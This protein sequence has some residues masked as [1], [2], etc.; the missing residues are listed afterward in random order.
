MATSWALC[1]PTRL[2]V[3]VGFALFALCWFSYCN[4]FCLSRYSL[5]FLRFVYAAANINEGHLVVHD[6]VHL[7][8]IERALKFPGIRGIDPEG[9]GR[10]AHVLLK[11]NPSYR[12]GVRISEASSSARNLRRGR[13]RV[14]VRR[15]PIQRLFLRNQVISASRT[16][17]YLGIN[18]SCK[19]IQSDLSGE[20]TSSVPVRDQSPVSAMPRV[21]PDFS[22]F[23]TLDDDESPVQFLD[24]L[25]ASSS[26]RPPSPPLP[27]PERREPDVALEKRPREESGPVPNPPQQR[28]RTTR[29]SSAQP[30]PPTP[31]PEPETEMGVW[32]PP[33]RRGTQPILA[34]DSCDNA[35]V[36]L[37]VGRA[38]L[39]PGD[40]E[41]ETGSSY[42]KL[43]KSGFQHHIKVWTL[44]L[45]GVL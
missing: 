3:H 2:G 22:D 19:N 18:L 10:A 6:G 44:F 1:A 31:E 23:I 36:A 12:G 37:A 8:D 32:N 14:G 25:G 45:R 30:P 5:R 11:Y 7:L 42:L 24:P 41:R 29:S 33:L 40:V 4:G 27:P 17:I 43:L 21:V 39:L 20:S 15:S 35:D 9:L 16:N 13:G 38:V 28:R 34:T 26:A